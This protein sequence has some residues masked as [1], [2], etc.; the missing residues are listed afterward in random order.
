MTKREALKKKK[1]KKKKPKDGSLEMWRRSMARGDFPATLK[2]L[3]IR[4]RYP[5]RLA[6]AKKLRPCIQTVRQT[7][8]LCT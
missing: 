5:F 3:F 1:K 4:A 2:P 6:I 8:V 7:F